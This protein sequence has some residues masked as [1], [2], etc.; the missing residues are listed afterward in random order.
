[1]VSKALDREASDRVMEFQVLIDRLRDIH[2]ESECADED[3]AQHDA[4]SPDEGARGRQRSVERS[5][6]DIE[7]AI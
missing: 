2:L 6:P 4:I 1:M 3:G 7:V 5:N